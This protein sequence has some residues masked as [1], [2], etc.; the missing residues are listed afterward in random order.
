MEEWTRWEPINGLSGKYSIN[1]LTI[2]EDKL[3]IQLSDHDKVKKIEIVFDN[4]IDGYRYTY[5]SFCFK[6]FGDLS[7]K[8]GTE[9]YKNWSFL[10]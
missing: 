1:S 6:I 2:A 3:I 4:G 10:K 8:H 9:F 5:E 7:E